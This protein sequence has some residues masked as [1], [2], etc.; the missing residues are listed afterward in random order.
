MVTELRTDSGAP[1]ESRR[2]ETVQSAQVWP[3]SQHALGVKQTVENAA[4]GSLRIEV[5][6][7]VR[8]QE[9]T[10]HILTF[11]GGET[12]NRVDHCTPRPHQRGS[13]GEHSRLQ[14]RHSSRVIRSD[15]PANFGMF[16]QRAEPRARRIE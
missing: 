6:S 12:T 13:I 9:R 2:E 1:D 16:P 5:K 4:V 15:A 14:H 10:H 7:W 3:R 11:L 8:L